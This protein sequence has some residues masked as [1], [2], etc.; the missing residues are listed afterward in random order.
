MAVRTKSLAI[1]QN[2]THGAYVDMYTVPT[3]FV[4]IVK[5]LVLWNDWNGTQALY[6]AV[7]PGGG[8]YNYRFN[9]TPSG[10]PYVVSP[11]YLVLAA[12]DKLAFLANTGGLSGATNFFVS[13]AELQL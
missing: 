4:T 6:V 13:G 11:L 12:G 8:Y 10:T 5:E 2:A 1:G 9:S 7:H 3:G